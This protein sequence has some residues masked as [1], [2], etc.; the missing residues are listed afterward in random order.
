MWFKKQ[1]FR[2]VDWH[3]KVYYLTAKKLFERVQSDSKSD[4][5]WIASATQLYKTTHI[6]GFPTQYAEG[7]MQIVLNCFANIELRKTEP[8]ILARTDQETVHKIYNELSSQDETTRKIKEKYLKNIIR[9]IVIYAEMEESVFVPYSETLE[10]LKKEWE[11]NVFNKYFGQKEIDFK[12]LYKTLE[13]EY[14]RFLDDARKNNELVMAEEEKDR[15]ELNALLEKLF[16]E[17]LKFFE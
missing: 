9:G 17:S 3:G 14:C 8:L 4:Y 5:N 10:K 16:A 15:K 2:L 7:I 13:L 1:K 12:E 11:S 6:P